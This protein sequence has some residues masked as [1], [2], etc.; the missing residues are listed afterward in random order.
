MGTERTGGSE[1]KNQ[2]TQGGVTK[3]RKPERELWKVSE[4]TRRETEGLQSREPAGRV[5]CF[6]MPKAES[7]KKKSET[8]P[9][10]FSAGSK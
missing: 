4:Q 7:C 2:L 8:C 6:S 3:Y 5:K 1:G 9:L 10:E